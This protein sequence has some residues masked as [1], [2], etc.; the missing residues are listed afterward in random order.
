MAKYIKD[1]KLYHRKLDPVEFNPELLEFIDLEGLSRRF[2]KVNISEFD[3]DWYNIWRF[4]PKIQ[5]KLKMKY[6]KP[7]SDSYSYVSQKSLIVGE[8][9]NIKNASITIEPLNNDFLH[10]IAYTPIDQKIP[11]QTTV[12]LNVKNP[13]EGTEN[14][15]PSRK[16]IWSRNLQF[17]DVRSNVTGLAEKPCCLVHYGAIDIGSE[18]FA[19]F[20]VSE[21]NT[22]IF[23]SFTLF[24]FA[25]SAEKKEIWIK[26]YDCYNVS[27]VELLTLM[28]DELQRKHERPINPNEIIP[29]W[30]EPPKI[31]F[32]FLDELIKRLQKVKEVEIVGSKKWIEIME[33]EK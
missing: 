16:F 18:I 27:M 2:L 19:K 8:D 20:E 29:E 10:L 28:K 5:Y 30:E 26:L 24:T 7:I 6:L 14:Q 25:I 21:V 11:L 15:L 22:N 12:T 9:K 17:P 33:N 1:V 4:I 31:I 32:E 23:G 3:D 13:Y